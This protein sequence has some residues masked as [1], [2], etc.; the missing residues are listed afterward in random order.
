[1]KFESFLRFKYWPAERYL[2]ITGDKLM[3]PV[4]RTGLGL[5]KMCQSMFQKMKRKMERRRRADFDYS[6]NPD[7]PFYQKALLTLT[8]T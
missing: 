7:I 4:A 1:M 3:P 8:T 2:Q 5:V 6:R